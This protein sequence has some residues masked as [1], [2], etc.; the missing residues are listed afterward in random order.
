MSEI[1][2][3]VRSNL[4][5]NCP[6]EVMLAELVLT[7]GGAQ[8]TGVD[9]LAADLFDLPARIGMPMHVGGLTEAIKHPAYAA[10]VGLVLFGEKSEIAANPCARTAKACGTKSVRGFRKC[11]MT[12]QRKRPKPGDTKN[13]NPENI[14][15]P[16][17][18]H[19]EKGEAMTAERRYVPEHMATIK[20]IGIG[21]GGC[22]AINRMVDAGIKG[23]DFFA[24]NTD[25]QALKI[26]TH[27]EH[28]AD[29][30]KSYARARR[31]SRSGDRPPS[32]R[33]I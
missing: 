31:G 33:R 17:S 11:G 19:P 9:S 21:G 6:P 27:G 2:K 22:N 32:R 29:R 5:E 25:V 30:P 23:A 8:L 12:T 3:I 10:L 1:F 18:I 15:T 4:A 7:G 14:S 26:F 24:V 28:A 13:D 20:V 16:R